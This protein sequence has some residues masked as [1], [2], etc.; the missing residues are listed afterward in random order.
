MSTHDEASETQVPGSVPLMVQCKS[1]VLTSSVLGVLLS[2]SVSATC[3]SHTASGSASAL[4][5]E[6]CFIRETG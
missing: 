4:T 2:G 6:S 3:R 5:T 1:E